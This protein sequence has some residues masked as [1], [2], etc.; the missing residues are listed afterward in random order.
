MKKLFVALFSISIIFSDTITY[1]NRTHISQSAV[2]TFSNGEPIVPENEIVIIKNVRIDKITEEGVTYIEEKV[3]SSQLGAGGIFISIAAIIPLI[4]NNSKNLDIT[5]KEY[6]K[7]SNISLLSLLLGGLSI[8]TNKMN[9]L[10][11]KKGIPCEDIIEIKDARG[12]LIEFNCKKV[13]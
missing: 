11:D 8:A 12:R 3:T 2:K 13:K 5:V 10:F 6:E 9:F 4:I 1:W 7:M